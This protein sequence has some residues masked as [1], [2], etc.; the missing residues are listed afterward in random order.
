MSPSVHSLYY[1]YVYIYIYI[2][3][4]FFASIYVFVSSNPGVASYQQLRYLFCN[5]NMHRKTIII[6]KSSN[7]QL[8]YDHGNCER[9]SN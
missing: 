9:A 1:I 8:A 5:I 6:F 2:Y 3:I 4:Y 7:P